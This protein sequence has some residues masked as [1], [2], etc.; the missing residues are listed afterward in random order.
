MTKEEKHVIIDK[1]SEQLK[2]APNFYL[3]DAST[4]N[5]EKTSNLRRK[6]F[7]NKVS[8]NVVKNTLLQK[9]L[10]RNGFAATELYSV[11]A[12]PTALMISADNAGLPAKV[13]K[14]FRK[15]SDRPVL[16]GAYVYE[17][18]YIGDENVEALANI[19]SR[20]ELI[21]GIIT[22]LQSPITNV[23]SALKSG[24][25]TIAGIVKTLEERGGAK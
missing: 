17:S 1:L 21:G 2:A 15:K 6:C 10:E 13:I 18:L 20:E 4:L 14:D 7:E 8:L 23:V 11:L 3:V 25:N 24:G 12:G 22:L 16:K 5:A 19:K 9:A